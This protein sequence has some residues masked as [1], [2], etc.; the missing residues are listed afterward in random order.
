MR[1][2]LKQS[3]RNPTLQSY[4]KNGE[5]QLFCEK[6]RKSRQIQDVLDGPFFFNWQIREPYA[7]FVK[8]SA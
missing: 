1:K 6:N 8:K 5:S 7:W 3:L 4:E 2:V